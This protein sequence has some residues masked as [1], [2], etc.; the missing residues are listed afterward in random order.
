MTTPTAASATAKERMN[1]LAAECSRRVLVT[2]KITKPFP[3]AV[4]IDS[5][6]PRILIQF[7]ISFYHAS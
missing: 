3:E 7:S 5:N 4:T 6:K 2:R 1:Q